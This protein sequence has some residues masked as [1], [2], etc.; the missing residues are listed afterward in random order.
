MTRHG[1]SLHQCMKIAQKLPNDLEDK[2]LAFQK[3]IIQKR[4]EI[5]FEMSQIGNMDETSI[6]FDLPGNRQ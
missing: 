4:K 1:L 6:C 2:I 5:S 3:Y